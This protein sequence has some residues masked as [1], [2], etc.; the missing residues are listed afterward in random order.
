MSPCFYTDYLNFNLHRVRFHKFIFWEGKAKNMAGCYSSRG[1]FRWF[2][3]LGDELNLADEV[4]TILEKYVCHLYGQPNLS[5]VKKACYRMFTLGKCSEESLPPNSDSLYQHILRVNYEAYIRK[6]STL[7]NIA[8][9]SPN[10]FGWILEGNHLEIKWGTKE[11]AP[12]S[13]LEYVMCRCKKGCNTKR[14]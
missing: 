9:P 12:D 11:S 2:A 3:R 14:C 13:I 6:R 8:A 1:V 7:N 5:S 4:F 10:G